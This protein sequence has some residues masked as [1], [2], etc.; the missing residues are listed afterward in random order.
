MAYAYAAA[1]VIIVLTCVFG[2]LLAMLPASA[3]RF[4]QRFY[5]KINWRM[6][7][8]SWEKE[9]RNTRRMGRAML[10]LALALGIFY[11]IKIIKFYAK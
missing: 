2:A 10:A 11:G 6:E 1:A 7:P 8:V 3:I 4:Q 9:L 5:E